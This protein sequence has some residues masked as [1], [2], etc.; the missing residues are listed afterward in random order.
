[1]GSVG[2]GSGVA[3][4]GLCPGAPADCSGGRGGAVSPLKTPRGRV[5]AE[6]SRGWAAL[7]CWLLDRGPQVPSSWGWWP[8]LFLTSGASPWGS[9]QPGS[10]LHQSEQARGQARAIEV[11]VTIFGTLVPRV[12]PLTLAAFHQ[13]QVTGPAHTLGAGDCVGHESQDVGIAGATGHSV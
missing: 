13:E 8:P 10:W 1:M 11:G 6:L 4:P 7:S 3:R 5:P 2:Q 12:T 9:A